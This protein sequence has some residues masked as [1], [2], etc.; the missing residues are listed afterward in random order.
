MRREAAFG[1]VFV[2]LGIARPAAAQPVDADELTKHGLSLRRQRR[3][4]EALTDFLRA[5]AV[6][7]AP[8][9]LAQIALAEQALGL[10]VDAETHL[11][12]ALLVTDDPWIES[13]RE[14]LA[15]GLSD[16]QSHL[17][18]LEVDADVAGAE[19]WVNGARGAT[20]PLVVPLRLEAGSVVIEVRAL[21]YATTRRLTSV[22]AG[23]TAHATI[24]LVPLAPSPP[25]AQAGAAAHPPKK[26]PSESSPETPPAAPVP[27][28][29]AAGSTPPSTASFVMFGAAAAG[30]AVGSYLGLR[31]ISTKSER[32]DQCLQ[33]CN[34]RGVALDEQ[35]RLLADRS[36]AWF[37]FGIA[38]AGVG[39]ALSWMSRWSA[40]SRKA[41]MLRLHVGIDLHG[42]GAVLGGTW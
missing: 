42:G 28:V 37:A 15:E 34:A 9:T 29:R 1:L 18:W 41:G 13:H 5:Y 38:T 2:T 36:T 12:S 19:L 25:A 30:I 39:V 26:I 14:L 27:P 35:A 21:G 20:L 6:F 11:R 7:P 32:D 31:T 10:W 17:G 8:R 33:V 16:I 40:G 22:D 3:D 23:E 4:A 24:H